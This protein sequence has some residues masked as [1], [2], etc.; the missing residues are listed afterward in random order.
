MKKVTEHCTQHDAASAFLGI[1]CKKVTRLNLAVSGAT[2]R[3]PTR[4]IPDSAGHAKPF[5]KILLH[6]VGMVGKKCCLK[7]EINF[8][9]LRLSFR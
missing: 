4:F 8:S 3:V 2:A 7:S 9:G 1:V 6:L 5:L